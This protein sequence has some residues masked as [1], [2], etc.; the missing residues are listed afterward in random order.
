MTRTKR[1][2]LEVAIGSLEDAQT[3]H[4]GGA[5]R[6]ELNAALALGGLTPSL[7]LLMEVK[8]AIPLP[9]IAMLRPRPAGF[10]YREA[11]FRVLR[12]DL[13]ILLNHGADGIAFGLLQQTGEVDL[14][15]CREVIRQIGQREAIFHRAFDVTPDAARTL[16]Q[17]VDLGIKR[18]MTSG[19]QENALKG[20]SQIAKLLEQARGRIE[21]LPA[22]G[23]NG[24]TVA[25][26]LARTGCDQVHASLRTLCLDRSGAARPQV[27]FHRTSMPA[28]DQY[29]VTSLEA[30]RE[31]RAKLTP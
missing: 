1:V 5:D 18:V 7:G 28:E 26:I 29:E 25:E 19:Q 2:L 3:A 13:E 22:A 27:R 4:Q 31:L 14:P 17:L 30:L 16:E 21:I 24:Q 6:V 8:Q 23:V 9:V 10:C 11:E 12:R 15:R 20:A